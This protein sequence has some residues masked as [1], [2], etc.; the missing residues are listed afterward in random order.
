M[1]TV[2]EDALA[3]MKVGLDASQIIHGLQQATALKRPFDAQTDLLQGHGAAFRQVIVG[4]QPQDLG[5]TTD[6]IRIEEDE[7]RR[8]LVGGLHRLQ[9]LSTRCLR[10]PEVRDNGLEEGLFEVLNGLNAIAD[11]GH[12]VTLLAQGIGEVLA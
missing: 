2:A 10:Q 12:V 11:L 6:I 7:H 1:H 3:L 4:A 9:G 8:R 5:S